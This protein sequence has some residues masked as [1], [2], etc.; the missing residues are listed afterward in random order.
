MFVGSVALK[1]C[2]ALA[3]VMYN[4][5]HSKLCDILTELGICVGKKLL[6]ELKR[7]D[8]IRIYKAKYKSSECQ[9]KIKKAK[10]KNRH[11]EEDENLNQ[12]GILYQYGAF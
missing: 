5:G 7:K 2:L 11:A 6:I 10:R 8:N 1:V 4:D 12:E 3:V 9:K